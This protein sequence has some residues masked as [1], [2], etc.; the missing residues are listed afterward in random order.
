MNERSPPPAS[1]DGHGRARSA[2]GVEQHRLHDTLRYTRRRCSAPLTPRPKPAA[3]CAVCFKNL[4]DACATY[5]L[6]GSAAAAS[7]AAAPRRTRRNALSSGLLALVGVG[8]LATL[9]VGVVLFKARPFVGGLAA[10]VA[11]AL[12]RALQ[13]L[14]K[15]PVVTRRMSPRPAAD[16]PLT[17][18]RRRL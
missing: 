16:R 12:G 9:A 11:I 18:R 13:L 5:E 2:G 1:R 15:A 14:V 6:D 7:A 3:P 4:C 17:R 10:I 8:Y